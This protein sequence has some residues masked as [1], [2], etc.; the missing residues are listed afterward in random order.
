MALTKHNRLHSYFAISH[1][2][3][4]RRNRFSLPVGRCQPAVVSVFMTAQSPNEGGSLWI[5][6][7]GQDGEPE[8]IQTDLSLGR[9][10]VGLNVGGRCGGGSLGI[11]LLTPLALVWSHYNDKSKQAIKQSGLSTAGGGVCQA[12]WGLLWEVNLPVDR[13]N[14]RQNHLYN[15]IKRPLTDEAHK[16]LQGFH[17]GER[18]KRLVQYAASCLSPGPA[19]KS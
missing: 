14:D 18:S 9:K 7:G 2:A 5:Q 11:P 15:R 1:R 8:C 16:C 10:E 4:E 17:G 6:G 12:Q 3:A 19:F 13:C